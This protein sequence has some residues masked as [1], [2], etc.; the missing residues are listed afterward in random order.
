MWMSSD[1]SPKKVEVADADHS[2]DVIHDLATL[3]HKDVVLVIL[4]AFACP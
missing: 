1:P 4:R 2:F 3:V